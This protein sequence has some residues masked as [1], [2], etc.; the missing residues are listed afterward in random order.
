[1]YSQGLT[2]S[3]NLGYANKKGFQSNIITSSMLFHL[4]I[5]DFQMNGSSKYT[6]NTDTFCL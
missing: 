4:Q 1:M 2:V 3:G 5:F 6:L